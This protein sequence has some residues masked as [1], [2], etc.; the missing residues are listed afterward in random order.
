MCHDKHGLQGS[1]GNILCT[2]GMVKGVLA[3]WCTLGTVLYVCGTKFSYNQISAT[4]VY[5]LIAKLAKLK[6][7][8]ITCNKVIESDLTRQKCIFF[9]GL[10]NLF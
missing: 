1:G 3:S 10:T 8:D 7:R 9:V 5:F 4:S 6:C 2:P